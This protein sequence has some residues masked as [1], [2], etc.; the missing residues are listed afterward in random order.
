MRK[1]SSEDILFEGS[2][3][4][5]FRLYERMLSSLVGVVETSKREDYEAEM[6]RLMITLMLR[7]QFPFLARFKIR[8]IQY[9][10]KHPLLFVGG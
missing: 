8:I 6:N 4:S 7:N 5:E 9:F 3:L 2:C 1:D 10:I